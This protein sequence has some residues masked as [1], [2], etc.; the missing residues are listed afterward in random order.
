LKSV[1]TLKFNLPAS[2]AEPWSA[3]LTFDIQRSMHYSYNESQ[4]DA[5]FLKFIWQST[6]CSGQVHCP[7]SG[8]SQNC[9]HSNR[10][11]SF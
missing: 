5:L 10:Y 4:R 8:V 6:T 2:M 3:F 1:F 11:L 7:S 9:I